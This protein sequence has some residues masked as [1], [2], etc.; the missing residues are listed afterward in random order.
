MKQ[1]L[2]TPAHTS[3]QALPKSS[4]RSPSR[5]KNIR[6][7]ILLSIILT[8]FS[9]LLPSL[10]KIGLERGIEQALSEQ[11]PYRAS[12]ESLEYSLLFNPGKITLQGL[13]IYQQSVLPVTS[14]G[15]LSVEISLLALLNKTIKLTQLTLDQVKLPITLLNASQIQFLGLTLPLKGENK[16]DETTDNEAFAYQLD[17][18][19][20]QL[21]SIALT[22]RTAEKTSAETRFNIDQLQLYKERDF[23]R[24]ILESQLNQARIDSNLQVHIA[25][26]SPKVLGTL[27]ISPFNLAELSPLASVFAPKQAH[28][29]KGHLSSHITFTAKMTDQG[30]AYY[31]QGSLSLNN[32]ELLQKNLSVTLPALSWKGDFHVFTHSTPQVHAKGA[33][34]L[35]NMALKLPDQAI[36]LQQS[37]TANITLNATLSPK[38]LKLSQ[39][40]QIHLSKLRLNH[41]DQTLEAKQIQ[42]QGSLDVVNGAQPSLKAK[43]K[44]TAHELTAQSPSEN[45]DSSVNRLSANL[46]S[47]VNLQL[48]LNKSGL[49]LHQKGTLDFNH[50]AASLPPL[51]LNSQNIHWQGLL[52]AKTQPEAP[53]NL[54]ANG[55]LSMTKLQAKHTQNNLILGQF[56]TLTVDEVGV[57]Q[58]SHLRLKG[59]NIRQLHA[60]KP[61]KP[62]LSKQHSSLSEDAGLVKT[63]QLTLDTI[64]LTDLNTLALGNLVL[65]GLESHIT[66][67]QQGEIRELAP[68]LT[69]LSS[70]QTKQRTQP[71]TTKIETKSSPVHYSLASLTLQGNNHIQ[72]KTYQAEPPLNKSIQITQLNIGAINSQAPHTNTPFELKLTI[73]EFSHLSSS[74]HAQ[75]LNPKI[76]LT[77]K[78][79]LHGLS[80]LDL[81]HFSEKFIGYKINSGQLTLELDT[82]IV[83]NQIK[84]Q[85]TL[86]LHKFEI[87]ETD[88]V[89]T[90]EFGKDFD[91]P[92]QTGLAMLQDKE[93]NIALDLP[94]TGDISSP[95]FELQS[96]INK[97]LNSALVTA[98]KTY[99]LLALQ[100]FGAILLA[101]EYALDQLSAVQLQ[102]VTFPAGQITLSKE[103][104]TYLSKI[105]HLLN[106][107]KALKLK[108][109]GGASPLD[110]PALLKIAQAKQ[111]QKLIAQQ[112][113]STADNVPKERSTQPKITITEQQVLT[114]ARQRQAHI[115][116]SLIT[117]G[118]ASEQIILCQPSLSQ[119]HKLP[120]VETGL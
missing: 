65:K 85:N 98:T 56:E 68:L 14:V 18:N 70:S 38:A 33:L 97:A 79:Q 101:G 71:K 22:L 23:Y 1:T 113:P 5:F 27:D 76:N 50:L 3:S 82:T 31:Q 66:L 104:S 77:A 103:M 37:V 12:I 34:N 69:P 48:A 87:I 86:Q 39:T 42:W 109:C 75:P 117:L 58:L 36:T 114:L 106:E 74:G 95:N 62:D 80:L 16:L 120:S 46:E 78:A 55:S 110:K 112:R 6:W 57:N 17:A 90:S 64:T 83:D 25:S 105:H 116:R 99:L 41:A 96:V 91:M 10:L 81:S 92:F 21:N 88:K 72:L 11:K 54:T 32:A 60:I 107:R 35:R 26:E 102:A 40:G 13:N 94:I 53:L 20:I 100:P 73:D 43:G 115:K 45:T 61:I 24:F 15:Q 59:L 111:A 28:S 108:L 51:V 49:S 47:E 63:E 67:S 52:N 9:L 84:A 30:L 119:E 29:L 19:H 44:L 7:L 89:K 2:A 93:D 8:G 4:N 118:T